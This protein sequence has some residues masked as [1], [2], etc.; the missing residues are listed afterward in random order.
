MCI[1]DSTQSYSQ[2]AVTLQLRRITRN[3]FNITLRCCCYCRRYC[4]LVV[5]WIITGL[6]PNA[7]SYGWALPP[8]G[9]ISRVALYCLYCLCCV[10]CTKFGN[11]ILIKIIKIVATRC[12]QIFRLKY[13]KS[14]SAGATPQTLLGS[15][16]RSSR[17]PNWWGGAS[18][19]LP[20]TISPLGLDIRHFGP[21]YSALRASILR[22]LRL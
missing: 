6:W 8:T 4:L 21:Q 12:Q 1:I 13:N 10:N 15:L 9:L 11:L 22:P 3:N 14:I 5:L 16:Q 19:P 7:F 17:P 2:R 20:R 18:C